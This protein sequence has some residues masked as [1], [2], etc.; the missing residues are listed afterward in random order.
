MILSKRFE[1]VYQ[2]D[3]TLEMI[4]FTA[5]YG[6]CIF[7]RLWHELD[8]EPNQYEYDNAIDSEWDYYISCIKEI[9]EMES[10]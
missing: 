6:D 4:D 3:Y 10:L 1:C 5:M 2:M 8:K 9:I 7:E